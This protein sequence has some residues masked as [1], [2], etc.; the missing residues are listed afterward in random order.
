M[1]AD[2]HQKEHRD[3]SGGVRGRTEVAERVCNPIGRTPMSTNQTPST[4]TPQS[5]LKLS[6]QPRGTHGGIHGSSHIC[7]RKWPWQAS[8]GGEALIPVKT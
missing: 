2:N 1:L 5:S 7:S 3:P 6:H 4:P 8:L